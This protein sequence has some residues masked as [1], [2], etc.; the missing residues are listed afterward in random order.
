M[1]TTIKNC[2]TELVFQGCKSLT[3]L[4]LP[5]NLKKFYHLAFFIH[6]LHDIYVPCEILRFSKGERLDLFKS[7]RSNTYGYA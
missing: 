6:N 7:N 1:K 5:S 3:A 4:Y 2:L